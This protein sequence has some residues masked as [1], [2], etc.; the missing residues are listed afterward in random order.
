MFVT[1]AQAGVQKRPTKMDS[2]FRGNDGYSAFIQLKLLSLIF[3]VYKI[4]KK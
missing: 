1:P 2:C 4:I 3:Y